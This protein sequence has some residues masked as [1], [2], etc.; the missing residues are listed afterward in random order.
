MTI[1]ELNNMRIGDILIVISPFLS[2]KLNDRL[3]YVGVMKSANPRE[4]GMYHFSI[5][6]ENGYA[7]PIFTRGGVIFE[8][9]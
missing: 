9:E 4:G 8:N 2:V 7:G 6:N 1:E 3:V 5:M